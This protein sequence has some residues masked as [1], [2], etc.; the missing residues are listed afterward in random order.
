MYARFLG[1]GAVALALA[2]PCPAGLILNGSFEQ[3]S[4]CNTGTF[5]TR[6]PGATQI[7]GWAIGGASVDYIQGYWQAADGARSVDLSG[8]GVF[9]GGSAA[10]SVSQTF[11]TTPGQQY[12][13]LF[14][15]AGNPDDVQGVKTLLV[16]AGLTTQTYTF[17]TTGKAKS[18]MG[19]VER[20]FLF[21]ATGASTTL[22]FAGQTPTQ[23][24][25]ALD[26]V[27]AEALEPSPAPPAVPEPASVVVLGLATVLAGA[28][29]YS[30]RRAAAAA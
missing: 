4:L 5:D 17:D 24:G 9:A 20:E 14:D 21:T 29:G 6:T 27:R 7:T 3:G 15:L 28:A 11:A 12:R 2:S 16:S 18:D 10:G 22:T 1:A 8:T 26:N 25:P 23:F 30:R 19:W 13:V